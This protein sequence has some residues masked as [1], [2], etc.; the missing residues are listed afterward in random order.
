MAIGTR[1]RPC[2]D[3]AF[4]RVAVPAD[5][6]CRVAPLPDAPVSLFRSSWEASHSP[7]S[8]VTRVF[9]PPPTQPAGIMSGHVFRAHL[10]SGQLHGPIGDGVNLA[11]QTA[12]GPFNKLFSYTEPRIPLGQAGAES[13][14]PRGATLRRNHFFASRPH[15]N[16]SAVKR[17]QG[18][19]GVRPPAPPGSEVYEPNFRRARRRPRTR[20]RRRRRTYDARSDTPLR[21]S[22]AELFLFEPG[23]SQRSPRWGRRRTGAAC[24][25]PERLLCS[26]PSPPHRS[27]L[28]GPRSPP[29][30]TENSSESRL[31]AVPRPASPTTPRRCRPSFTSNIVCFDVLRQTARL[32]AV[33]NRPSESLE[34]AD[35]P[36]RPM[37]EHRP[38]SRPFKGP[39]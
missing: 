7:P 13:I 35:P 32:S 21:T 5:R 2:A 3:H 14:A 38:R 4:R 39:A 34:N 22:R 23:R 30:K 6:R 24:S 29:T 16:A 11:G 37:G 18:G 25:C 27:A 36:L 33:A 1:P 9:A 20:R 15:R 31:A 17:A 10:R 19:G 28:D 12:R 26:P 8:S